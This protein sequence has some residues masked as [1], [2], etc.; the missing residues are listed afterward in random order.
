MKAAEK[1]PHVRTWVKISDIHSLILS[2][3]FGS[4]SCT[5]YDEKYLEKSI[6]IFHVSLKGR[7][8]WRGR[9]GGQRG[10]RE[11]GGME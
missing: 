1:F 3:I 11:A 2:G 8:G 9:N 6:R 10:G 7:E 5:C 4:F